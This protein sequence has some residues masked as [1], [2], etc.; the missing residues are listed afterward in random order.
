MCGSSVRETPD[1]TR[2]TCISSDIFLYA[3]CLIKQE[4]VCAGI[5]QWQDISGTCPI[6]LYA[7][8]MSSHYKVTVLKNY[9]RKQ[10]F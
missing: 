10:L 4:D 3:T 6:C 2:T 8:N 5:Y 9:I 1:D 7:W